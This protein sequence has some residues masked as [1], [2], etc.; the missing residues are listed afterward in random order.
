MMT[1]IALTKINPRFRL[2][3][4]AV[5]VTMGFADPAFAESQPLKQGSYGCWTLTTSYKA[6]PAP[7]SQSEINRRALQLEVDPNSRS[8]Q[9]VGLSLVPAIF[10][11]VVFDGKG[12]YS[13]PAIKQS[14]T[15]GFDKNKGLPTFTGDLGAM[16]LVEYSGTGTG[17]VVGWDGTNFHCGLEGQNVAPSAVSSGT[18]I[19]N[20]AY[21]SW[22]GPTLSSAKISDFDGRFEGNYACGTADSRLELELKSKDDGTISAI[23]NFGG[24]KT[25]EFS[26]SL[27]S[28]SMKGTW[29]GTHFI[30]KGDKWIKQPEGYTMVDIEGDITTKGVAGTILF[31]SCD[32]FAAARISR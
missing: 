23:F 13:I 27:G 11:N 4:G 24:I 16:Q 14:G 1:L 3:V 29:K 31:S 25:P 22:V 18:K 26:Y 5:L 32:S 7:D 8:I 19:P 6:P 20:A 17:F 21:V 10:G 15:Y 30:L 28:Y 2:F 9:P 12:R